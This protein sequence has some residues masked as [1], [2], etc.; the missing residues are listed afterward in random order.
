[1]RD[2]LGAG[3]N[4]SLAVLATIGLSSQRFDFSRM[5]ARLGSGRFPIRSVLGAVP[6]W[7]RAPHPFGGARC[8][9]GAATA[10]GA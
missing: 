10:A 8:T 2:R 4:P 9:R 6:V 3:R 5:R 1:M 7:R